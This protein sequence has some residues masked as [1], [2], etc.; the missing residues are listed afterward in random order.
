M[1]GIQIFTDK[2]HSNFQVEIFPSENILGAQ[3]LYVADEV[4]TDFKGFGVAITGASC[5]ELSLMDKSERKELLKNIY[6]KDG[7]GLSIGRLSI[8]SS[9]Y[10]AELYSYDDVPFDRELKHF[11]VKRDERYIIPMIKEILEVNPELYLFASPWSPPGWMKTEGMM[12]GG[13]MREEF[14]DCYADYIIKFIKAYETYGIKISAITP[15]NEPN[16]QQTRRMPA[17]IWHP[18]IEAKFVKVL[19]RKLDENGMD[20]RIWL[21]DHSFY[22]TSRV[23]WQLD[24][25]K[26]LAECCDSVAFHYYAGYIEETKAVTERYPKLKLQFT[27]GG[28][29]L[30]DHYDTDWCKWGIMMSEALACG[31]N[32]FTGW[33]LMLN[34]MG[35]P[36]IG[37]FWCGGLVTRNGVTGELAFSGQYKAFSHIAPYI[38]KSSEIRALSVGN[39]FGQPIYQYPKRKEAPVGFVIDNHDGRTVAV[40]INPNAEKYQTQI[41]LDGTM[42]YA[43]LMPESIS[44]LIIEE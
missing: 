4:N 31:Y 15:Q 28:P 13:Y 23:L 24:N 3:K 38:N 22:G 26:D 44:T 16:T 27:E 29:R 32:S 17:C 25:V 7:L 6:S 20:T 33:N 39:Y 18:E 40:V 9:D 34:E 10:S 14:I 35:G 37:P 12:C 1:K 30:T 21:F 5:Y 42:W 43:E 11:S 41:V 19:R 8:G 2:D 36:N